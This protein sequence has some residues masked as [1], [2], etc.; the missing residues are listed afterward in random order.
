MSVRHG[1][2]DLKTVPRCPAVR[3]GIYLSCYIH[4]DS[5]MHLKQEDPVFI[6]MAL[7]DPFSKQYCVFLISLNNAF[8]LNEIFLAA[9]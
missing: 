3:Y 4:G 1:V 9:L 6:C 8:T 2:L 5:H 7:T